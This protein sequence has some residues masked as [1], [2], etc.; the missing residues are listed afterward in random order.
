MHVHPRSADSRIVYF[1]RNHQDIYAVPRVGGEAT[2]V[3]HYGSFSV[4]LDYPAL[5]GD[6][7]KIVLLCRASQWGR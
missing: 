4:T 3:T 5:S 6:G 1:L 2:P 7:K